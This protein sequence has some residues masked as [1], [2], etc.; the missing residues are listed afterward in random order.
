MTEPVLEISFA[1]G[2]DES[3]REESMDP[4][5][6]FTTL[7]NIRQN[8]AGGADKRQGFDAL[9]VTALDDTDIA[10]GWRLFS[11]GD[12]LCMID[13]TYIYV[14]SEALARWVNKGRVPEATALLRDAPS[15]GTNASVEDIVYVNGYIVLSYYAPFSASLRY[16]AAVVFDESSGSVVRGPEAVDSGSG[17]DVFRL[18]SY[19]SYAIALTGDSTADEIRAKYLDTTS[20]T[21]VALGWQDIG[22][23]SIDYGTGFDC[24]NCASDDRIAIAFG[25]VSSSAERITVSTLNISGLLQTVDVATTNPITLTGEGGRVG[26][27]ENGSTLWLAYFDDLDVKVRG[28]DP[29]DITTTL[30]SV[31]T[32]TTFGGSFS[33]VSAYVVDTGVGTAT[34]YAKAVDGTSLAVGYL[35]HVREIE[36]AAGA[37]AAASADVFLGGNSIRSRPFVRNGRVYAHFDSAGLTGPSLLGLSNDGVL[38]DCT[39]PSAT[40]DFYLRPVAVAVQRPLHG[41]N[42]ACR[43]RAA[44]LDSTRYV[45]PLVLTQG[46]NTGGA[47]L[48]EY[49]FADPQR[50]RTA[51]VNGSLCLGGGV[52]S[53]FD[54]EHAF[55]AAF[56]VAPS[57]PQTDTS[58]SGS[59]DMTYGRRYVATFEHVDADGKWHTSGVSLPCEISG[60][61][62]SKVL[63][64]RVPPCT[65]T[66]RGYGMPLSLT[67]LRVVFY[68]TLDVNNGQPPY[69]RVGA[70]GNDPYATLVLFV[71]AVDDD[72]LAANALLYGTGNL[73]G[74]SAGQDH[75]APPGLTHIASYNGMIV[76]ASG[77]NIYG[78]SQPI[79]GEGQW[80]SPLFMQPVDSDITAMTVQDGAA[81]AFTEAGCWATAG[82]PPSDN[83]QQGGLGPPRRL[84]V[85]AGCISA[86]S[87]VTTSK[88]TFYRSRRGLEVLNRAQTG[89]YVGSPVQDTLESWPI[90]TSAVLDMKD[91]QSFVR[92]SLAASETD[93]VVSADGRDLVFDLAAGIWQSRD[94]KRGTTLG[95]SSQ[96]ACIALV[97]GV[98][99]YCWLAS[100]GTVYYER[101]LTDSDACLDGTSWNAMKAITPWVHISGTQGEQLIDQVLLLA[102]KS[103]SHELTISLAFDYI[104]TWVLPKTFTSDQLDVMARQW[105]VKEVGQTTSNAVR[106]MIED[107]APSGTVGTGA[108]STWVALTLNG[109]AHRGPKRSSAAQRGGT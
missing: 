26:L 56:Q 47:R 72:T 99:R 82:D 15:L 32:V 95:Q 53:I 68:A 88:G 36:T 35:T 98:R 43:A 84:S 77:R 91:S 11:R 25:T 79:D 74:T 2:F 19:G 63:K 20:P 48:A 23:M 30:A 102:K 105:L 10:A 34:V 41:G 66:S 46:G 3:S 96:D 70:T 33:P 14:Y 28:L 62:S 58:A 86:S 73:P 13:G 22:T 103:S 97:D 83:A 5:V 81:I 7:E 100:D 9:G 94:V 85:D 107:A 31:F 52:T 44:A 78:S 50:W 60:A 54:S 67:S 57:M 65:I 24:S 109:Q 38:C 92:F 51:T 90:V 61:Q 89:L 55:E 45:S 18:A 12:Q 69:Y 106:V 29:S 17:I 64:V 6:A 37:A 93:G 76:G 40:E 1:G 108:G 4:H 75:R 59:T 21:T 27:S 16:H 104:D 39:Y 101:L 8:K 87:V 71:D 49:N 42:F 80:F